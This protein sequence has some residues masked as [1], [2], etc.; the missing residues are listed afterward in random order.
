MKTKKSGQSGTIKNV[1]QPTQLESA[2]FNATDI[3]QRCMLPFILLKD[4]AYD[5]HVGPEVMGISDGVYVGVQKAEMTPEAWSTLRT[6]AKNSTLKFLSMM[7]DYKETERGFEWKCNGVPIYV[8]IIK[9]NYTF[10]KRPDLKLFRLEEY[11]IPN[12]FDNYWKARFII[13]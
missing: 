8:Q 9:K 7:D 1:F 4:T 13:R 3:L 6:F 12:P 11:R 10:F 5:V 2:L